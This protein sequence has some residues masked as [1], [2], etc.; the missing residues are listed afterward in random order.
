MSTLHIIGGGLSGLSAAVS[1]AEQ[2]WRVI[3]HEAAAQAGGRCRSFHD[4][5]IGRTIDNGN[6]LVLGIN[7]ATLDFLDTIGARDELLAVEPARI[8]FLDLRNGRQWSLRPGPPWW[9]LMAN[10][11]IPDATIAE[12]L[13]S[14]RLLFA[15]PDATVSG[16]LPDGVLF[17]RLWSPLATAALNTDPKDAS[18]RLLAAVVRPVLLG[19]AQAS[20]PYIA[21]DGLSQAFVEPAVAH[22]EAKGGSVR[23]GSRLRGLE[24]SSE[25]VQSLRFG[26]D[27]EALDPEDR[28]ILAVPPQAAAQLLP[29]LTL[30][31]ASCAIVNAHFRLDRPV[32]LPGGAPL[33][34]LIGGTAQWLFARADV[35][36]VTVS[37]ADR[38]ANKPVTEIA[39][40][41]WVDV[42]RAMA[43]GGAAMPLHRIVKEQRATFAQTPAE[44]ARRPGPNAADLGN[45]VLAGDWTATGLPATIEGSVLSGRRAVASLASR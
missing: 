27:D 3:V 4:A 33:V 7:R 26:E 11:G 39:E 43:L 29:K 6:H 25:G 8:P 15:G 35:V 1:A 31:L 22:I 36:A 10:R 30:P 16:S 23:L 34:G 21:R 45:L 42:A 40:T 24:T 19:G 12:F 2:G 9:P 38:L 17:E 28:I 37:A 18:A 44:V 5:A 32:T 20:R 14:T 41:L 13:K